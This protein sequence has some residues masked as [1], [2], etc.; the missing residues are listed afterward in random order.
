MKANVPY[1]LLIDFN[2]QLE[3]T[4]DTIAGLKVNGG[5][6]P[7]EAYDYALRMAANEGWREDTSRIII[8]FAD[9]TNRSEQ[10]LEEAIRDNNTE[11]LGI[12]NDA[13]YWKKAGLRDVA[14]FY[15]PKDVIC[16]TIDQIIQE[17]C[18]SLFVYNF[19]R[20]NK[21]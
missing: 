12:V 10:R 6:D 9:D 15:E 2:F 4:L 1:E 19:V 21:V 8:L 5:V 20:N 11:I 18:D 13:D 17:N 7:Q 3:A 16:N 14:N